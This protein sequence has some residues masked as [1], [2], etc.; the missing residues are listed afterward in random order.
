[1]TRCRFFISHLEVP[2]RVVTGVGILAS[3]A[4]RCGLTIR[5]LPL[6]LPR[7]PAALEAA[8]RPRQRAHGKGKPGGFRASV[9]TGHLGRISAH[10]PGMFKEGM[11]ATR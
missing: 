7:T 6:P 4:P 3:T 5:D 10:L 2:R 1:M 11:T 8:G 9:G